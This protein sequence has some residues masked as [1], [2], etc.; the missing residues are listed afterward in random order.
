[1]REQEMSRIWIVKTTSKPKRYAGLPPGC[2]EGRK[3]FVILKGIEGFRE[4]TYIQLEE[5]FE[6]DNIEMLQGHWSK[7]M[8]TLFAMNEQ[9]FNELRNCLRRLK[10]DIPARQFQW[11]FGK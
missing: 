9:K 11:I 1:M 3:V 5:I 2:S 6:L 8:T 7:R 4:D 10:E